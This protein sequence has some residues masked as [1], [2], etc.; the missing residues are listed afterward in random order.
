MPMVKNTQRWRRTYICYCEGHWDWR[1]LS[2]AGSQKAP[3]CLVSR[4]D[5]SQIRSHWSCHKDIVDR[6]RQRLSDKVAPGNV[7]LDGRFQGERVN[8]LGKLVR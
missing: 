6:H 7:V 3:D 1:R 8:A 4:L 5:E 2:L